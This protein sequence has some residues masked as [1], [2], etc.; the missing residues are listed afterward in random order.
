MQDDK[1]PAEQVDNMMK[2]V[3]IRDTVK[4]SARSQ[5][6]KKDFGDK[7]GSGADLRDHAAGAQRL[8]EQ[9]VRH[10]GGDVVV[11]GERCEPVHGEVADP[12]HEDREVDGQD[13]E[14]YC[15][16]GMRVIVEVE[17]CVGAL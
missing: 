17:A 10:D 4:G 1:P 15:E 3:R 5:T 2:I 13:P 16:N 7:A 14:H 8:D 12:D 9:D 6:Q 11:G